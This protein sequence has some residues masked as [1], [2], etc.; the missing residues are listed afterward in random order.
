M[1]QSWTKLMLKWN[2]KNPTRLIRRDKQ[3]WAKFKEEQSKEEETVEKLEVSIKKQNHELIKRIVDQYVDHI[4]TRLQVLHRLMYD[5]DVVEFKDIQKLE[6]LTKGL[7]ELEKNSGESVQQT[8]SEIRKIVDNNVKSIQ[9]YITQQKRM[10]RDL[11]FDREKMRDRS[12][13]DFSVIYHRERGLL[14]AAKGEAGD[15]KR[16]F[17]EIYDLIDNVKD[18]VEENN[19]KKKQ[20]K[21]NKILIDLPKL[22]ETISKMLKDMIVQ[23]KELV[24]METYYVVLEFRTDKIFEELKS[25][26]EKIEEGY[27]EHDYS[28]LLEELKRYETKKNLLVRKE[29]SEGKAILKETRHI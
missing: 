10:A 3:K 5:A 1:L 2:R 28:D 24:Q 15:L 20:K 25:R 4:I 7:E 8:I 13:W 11:K 27:T 17:K 29:Y 19:D 9:K 21:K 14:I 6:K 16:E 12:L 22:K 23:I 26:I 18:Y